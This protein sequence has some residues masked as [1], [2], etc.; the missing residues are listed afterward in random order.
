MNKTLRII[1]I[2]CLVCALLATI[3]I[4]TYVLW[5]IRL[6]LVDVQHGVSKNTNLALSH[7]PD[8]ADAYRTG[9][10]MVFP[11]GLFNGALPIINMHVGESGSKAA[12]IIDTASEMLLLGD[13]ERC[14]SCSTHLFGGARGSDST[15]LVHKKAIIQFASQKDHVEFRTEDM[16]I[17][18]FQ[19]QN[20][21]FG[22]VTH[23]E[24]LSNDTH[25]TFNVMG[26]GGAQGVPHA[27]LNLLHAQLR[28]SHPRQF[29]FMLGETGNENVDTQGVFVMGKIPTSL[30]H[31]V[32]LSTRIQLHSKPLTPYKYT[33]HVLSI[34][35]H[36]RNHTPIPFPGIRGLMFDTGSNRSVLPKS[37]EPFFQ[38]LDTLELRFANNQRLIL[39]NNGLMYNRTPTLPL[40]KFS[41]DSAMVVIGTL[42]LSKFMAFEFTLD[43]TPYIDFYVRP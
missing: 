31:G 36:M 19:F 10:S 40:V 7:L 30:L 27:F 3:G 28:P 22:L 1:G 18:G 2:V 21:R 16:F 38:H 4:Y 13:S 14:T 41:P 23:R 37:I 39:P 25:V 20:L 6:A 34:I 11:I 29:G 43:P 24:S 33:T 12:A 15:A 9:D 17:D 26:I 8:L 35:G 5:P 42:A 32:S